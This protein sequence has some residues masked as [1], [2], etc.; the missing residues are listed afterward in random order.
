MGKKGKHPVDL[1]SQPI[2]EAS[3]NTVS[4]LDEFQNLEMHG[5]SQQSIEASSKY[6]SNS[7][8][9][10]NNQDFECYSE[11]FIESI[12]ISR[13]TNFTSSNND[14]Q[15]TNANNRKAPE[16]H[17]KKNCCLYCKKLYSRLPEHLE[18]KHKNEKEVKL[19]SSM[20]KGM[21]FFKKYKC[22]MFRGICSA[23]SFSN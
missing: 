10:N 1:H 15:N 12:P 13:E 3:S 6:I 11:S 18:M 20:Q 22:T 7:Q 19:F 23:L 8:D 9:A 21:S 4:C 16:G 5:C 14:F 2:T 17:T